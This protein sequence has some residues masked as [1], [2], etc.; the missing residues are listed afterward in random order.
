MVGSGCRRRRAE[1]RRSPR[2]TTL[3]VHTPEDADLALARGAALAAANTPRYEAATVGLAVHAE[4]HRRRRPPRWP[5][6]DTWRRWG[7]AR[8]PTTTPTR[9]DLST[10]LSDRTCRTRTPKPRRRN[11][12]FVLSAARCRPLRCRAWSRWS[13]SLAVAIRPTADQRPD[14]GDSAVV[15]NSQAPVPRAGAA[16]GTATGSPGDHPGPDPRRSGGAAHRLRGAP[17]AVPAPAVPA[18]APAA[19]G[20]RARATACVR[21]GRTGSRPRV[22]ASCRRRPP[23]PAPAPAPAPAFVPPIV[24]PIPIVP[25]LLPP[26]FQVPTRST[27]VPRYPT[28]TVTPTPHPRHHTHPGADAEPRTYVDPAGDVSDVLG[29]SGDATHVAPSTTG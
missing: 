27:P 10:D 4:R 3:P 8:C 20:T 6:P 23:P 17:A 26:I 11:A 9:G 19:A 5:P 28:T 12:A 2:G 24:V 14:P 15:S 13:I 7:T 18:Q 21:P 1:D 25:S 29:S 22:A 16:A